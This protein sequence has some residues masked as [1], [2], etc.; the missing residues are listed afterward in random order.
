MP[1]ESF[2]VL[3]SGEAGVDTSEAPP[4]AP[5][6]DTVEV[7]DVK[8]GG[9]ST[10]VDT[11]EVCTVEPEQNEESCA[12]DLTA[13]KQTCSVLQEKDSGQCQWDPLLEPEKEHSSALVQMSDDDD[14]E[15]VK[16]IQDL[17]LPDDITKFIND[18]SP[19]DKDLRTTIVFKNTE[20]VEVFRYDRGP[21][22]PNAPEDLGTR[23]YIFIS[24]TIV[25]V[26]VLAT[27]GYRTYKGLKIQ[28]A[29]AEARRKRE[30]EIVDAGIGLVKTSQNTTDFTAVVKA[31]N[32]ETTLPLAEMVGSNS[33][34]EDR[35]SE[36][37]IQ[38]RRTAFGVL[39]VMG[40]SELTRSQTR[41]SNSNQLMGTLTHPWDGS[42]RIERATRGGTIDQGTDISQTWLQPPEEKEQ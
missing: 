11:E 1:E 34:V 18:V 20:G 21:E 2:V 37:Q 38:Q 27:R 5:T 3:D 41:D 19:N 39:P 24:S 29:D 30:K 17:C 32:K 35:R 16:K 42:T 23:L 40:T 22:L 33:Q 8:Q 12:A 13:S 4:A 25:I 31:L 28:E 36:T 15:N 14:F 7:D 9:E 10:E 6:R 26:I